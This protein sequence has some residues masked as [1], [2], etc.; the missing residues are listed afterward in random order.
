MNDLGS[1]L[2]GS[3]AFHCVCKCVDDFDCICFIW[4]IFMA[5]HLQEKILILF[6]EFW[7]IISSGFSKLQK[8]VP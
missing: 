1:R 7:V 3:R 4:K 2:L 8:A 6:A 5:V